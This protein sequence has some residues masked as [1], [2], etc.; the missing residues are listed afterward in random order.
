M[1]LLVAGE[2]TAVAMWGISIRRHSTLIR[3]G[4]ILQRNPIVVRSLH[5]FETAYLEYKQQRQ[6]ECSRGNFDIASTH[7]QRSHDRDNDGEGGLASTSPTKTLET[8]SLD[9]VYRLADEDVSCKDIRRRLDRKLYFVV[10]NEAAQWVFP[11]VISSK[12]NVLPLADLSKKNMLALLG[13]DWE[14]YFVGQ[15]PVT[16]H[17]QIIQDPQISNRTISRTL[18]VE[19]YFFCAQVVHGVMRFA[20]NASAL[21]YQW[22]TKEELMQIFDSTYYSSLSRVLS[23]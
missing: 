17:C 11:S 7:H 2:V 9:P 13:S 6:L 22:C 5:P 10:K 4:T 1:L 3:A 21:D 12:S 16:H 18:N 23:Y 15:M 20:K 19:D 8:T 14:G